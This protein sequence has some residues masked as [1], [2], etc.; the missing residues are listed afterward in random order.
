MDHTDSFDE[1]PNGL[2]DFAT[3]ESE[4]RAHGYDEVLERHW[5]PLQE[6]ETHSH[7]FDAHALIVKGEMWLMEDRRTQHLHT[8]DT[9][10]LTHGTPHSE[11]YGS[12]GATYWVARRTAG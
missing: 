2:P 3:F 9:F 6:V 7:P 12:S 5:T 8:G 11:R 1:H 4:M 10:D